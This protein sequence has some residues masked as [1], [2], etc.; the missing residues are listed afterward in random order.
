MGVCVCVC[1][2]TCVCWQE[3]GFQNK[4]PSHHESEKLP[5]NTDPCSQ[6]GS[7]EP[8]SPVLEPGIGISKMLSAD[9]AIR[10]QKGACEQEAG[11]KR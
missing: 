11:N 6:T 10:A 9:S 3:P 2:R 7:M 4:A 1:V 5:R 8:K